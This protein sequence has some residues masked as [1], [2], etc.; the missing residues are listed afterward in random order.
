M[1]AFPQVGEPIGALALRCPGCGGTQTIDGLFEDLDS[2]SAGFWLDFSAEV[3]RIS[4]AP[5]ADLRLEDWVRI[6]EVM[7]RTHPGWCEKFEHLISRAVQA[8]KKA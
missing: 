4:G 6:R 1:W 8:E 2:D 7:S 5:G 3:E